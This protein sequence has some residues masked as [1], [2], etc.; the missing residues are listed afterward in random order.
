MYT[1]FDEAVAYLCAPCILNGIDDIATRPDLIERCLVLELPPIGARRYEDDFWTEFEAARPRLLGTLYAALSA[2]LVHEANTRLEQPPRMADFARWVV[3]AEP[4]LGWAPGTSLNAYTRNLNTA[5]EAALEASPVGMAVRAL[6]D[7]NHRW[8]GTATQLLDELERR[9]GDASRGWNWPQGPRGLT[10]ALK[11]LA[12]A[13][14]RVGI[15]I[16]QKHMKERTIILEYTG[17]TA[18]ALSASTPSHNDDDVLI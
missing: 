15:G 13:L 2:S 11:R 12:P 18:L 4:A 3:A 5:N 14:R 16:T 10:N 17:K 6:L 9:A 1:D 8:Q 7:Y